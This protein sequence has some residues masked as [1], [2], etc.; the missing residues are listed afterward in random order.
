MNILIRF[1][2]FINTS[3]ASSLVLLAACTVSEPETQLNRGIELLGQGQY[4]LAIVHLSQTVK[5]CP[6]AAEAYGR[7]AQA[8]FRLGRW[9]EA[10]ADATKAVTLNPKFADAFAV[11]ADTWLMLNQVKAALNDA[12]KAVALN[13]QSAWYNSSCG[14]AH[15]CMKNNAKALESFDK[16]LKISPDYVNALRGRA[17]VYD[18]LEKWDSAQDDINKAVAAE[19]RNVIGLLI[20]CKLNCHLGQW[21]KAIEDANAV[22]MMEPK[23]VQA[24]GYRAWAQSELANWDL[25]ISDYS[26]AIKLSAGAAVPEFYIGRANALTFLG[27]YN[28]ALNDCLQAKQIN[29]SLVAPYQIASEAYL[30]LGQTDNAI[31]SATT[32][33]KLDPTP[34]NYNNRGSIYNALGKMDLSVQ[35]HY[36]AGQLK[37]K[38]ESKN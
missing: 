13:P 26:Q 33:I 10:L 2:P 37:T 30:Q 38:D 28:E 3:I 5:E 21:E 14:W 29:P 8:Y 18:T 35:D 23:N 22:T 24:Y 16:A 11:R 4:N 32:A 20:K 19:P 15:Q 36:T 9:T 34:V 1:Y 7:R 6:N 17:T 25:A 31:Q 12:E 27:R